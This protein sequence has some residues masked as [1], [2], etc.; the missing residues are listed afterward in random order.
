M[1]RNFQSTRVSI[2]VALSLLGV[3]DLGLAAYSWKLAATPRPPQER[4]E[5]ERQQLKLL[6]ADIDRAVKIRS[7]MPA[8]QKQCDDFERS[9]FPVATGYSSVSAE[10]GSIAAKSGIHIDT[11]SFKQKEIPE[12]GLSEVAIEAS[13]EGDYGSIVR[14]L[15]G[16]Q[17]SRNL[18]AVDSLTLAS[19]SQSQSAGGAIR[20]SLNARTYFRMGA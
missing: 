13:I 18:Y 1:A 2:L 19:Q 7:R 8:M 20:V 6:Q 17:R 11:V 12:R 10:I 3:A 14:F 5:A 15:N 16:L 4:L 9:L